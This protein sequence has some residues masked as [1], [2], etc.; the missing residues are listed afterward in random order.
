MEQ[1]MSEQIKIREIV[2]RLYVAFAGWLS[3]YRAEAWEYADY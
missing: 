1:S 2:D 3:L